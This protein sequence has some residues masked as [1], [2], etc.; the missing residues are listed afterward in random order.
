MKEII[1]K[2]DIAISNLIESDHK[3]LSRRLSERIISGRLAHYLMPLFDGYDVD[4]EYNGDMDKPNDRKALD[5]A[6]NRLIEIGYEPNEKNNYKLSP[7][8]II[9]KR[10]TNK[11]NLVVIEVKK[12]IAPDKD[13]QYDLIKLEHLTVDYSGN[14]YNYSLGV[15]LV[16]GTGSGTGKVRMSFY[17]NGEEKS[18]DNIK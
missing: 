3:I 6:K 17:Q 8:I 5:I 12:D 11:N 1:E 2:I 18:R 7:D 15:A 10:E 4:P 13:K 9:H 16:L 14:H